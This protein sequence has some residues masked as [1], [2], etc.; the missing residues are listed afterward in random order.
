MAPNNFGRVGSFPCHKGF[1][2]HFEKRPPLSRVPI[3]LVSPHP[4]LPYSIIGFL[5]KQA[6]ERVHDPCSPGFYSCLFLVYWKAAL[7][8]QS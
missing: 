8:D 7:G 5:E 1:T 6:V 3:D 4:Q 2:F